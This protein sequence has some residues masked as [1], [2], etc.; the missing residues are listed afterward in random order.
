M[1]SRKV[2][3]AALSCS[4][5]LGIARDLGRPITSSASIL[6]VGCGY[7][8]L[9]Q[10]FRKQGLR[11]EGV[12]VLPFWG[13]AKGRYWEHREPI[14][15]DLRDHLF[16]AETRPYRIPFEDNTFDLIVSVQVFE[17]VLDYPTTFRELARVLKPDGISIHI[18][19]ARGVPI[20]P[21][22]FVPLATVLRGR[23]WLG[24]WAFLGIRNSFQR[25]LPWREV[26][27]R[28]YRFLHRETH[29]PTHRQ[30]I[31][32]GG[33]HFRR[34]VSF[35]DCSSSTIAAGAHV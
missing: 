13:E 16:L 26:L 2:E 3:S 1:T 18:F 6:D 14:S 20:E 22:A 12:D 10:E 8:D 15:A 33:E 21:H 31:R 28:N 24:A 25:A 9:V 4:A 34:C 7:G 32:W 11:A 5:V 19:P 30:I 17:H 27:K 23:H 29:Y 35:P